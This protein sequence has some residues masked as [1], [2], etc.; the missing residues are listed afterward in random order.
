MDCNSNE[1][2]NGNDNKGGEQAT[3]MA[4]KRA[5]AMATMVVGKKDGNGDGSK[6]NG[7]GNEGDW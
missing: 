5:M 2:G 1:E 4:T 7:D 6:S 3:V